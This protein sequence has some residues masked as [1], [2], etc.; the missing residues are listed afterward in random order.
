MAVASRRPPIPATAIVTAMKLS[1]REES[2]RAVA[3]GR[4]RRSGLRLR[5]RRSGNGPNHSAVLW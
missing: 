4:R 3:M 5:C 2:R 1:S